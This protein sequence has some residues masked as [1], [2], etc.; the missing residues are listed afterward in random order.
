VTVASAQVEEVL[1]AFRIVFLV[2]LYLFIWRVVRAVA[3]DPGARQAAVHRD[4]NRPSDGKLVVVAS[5]ILAVGAE[6]G[7]DTAPLTIGRIEENDLALIGD[8]YASAHHARFE[9]RRDGV[10]VEDV[11]STNGTFV[12][13][14]RIEA[15]RRLEPGDV[16][17]VGETDLRYDR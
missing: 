12:N 11:G 15:P 8:E 5:P 13:G 3:R 14:L 6:R 7:F 9:R 16:V 2:V 4:G 1:L 10:Y 17:R